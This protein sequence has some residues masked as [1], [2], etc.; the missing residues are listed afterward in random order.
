MAISETSNSSVRHIRR[1]A[2]TI[3]LTSTW[4]SRTPGA[5]TVPSF[6]PFVCA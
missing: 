6:S 1:N 2:P 5:V 3:G 4:S